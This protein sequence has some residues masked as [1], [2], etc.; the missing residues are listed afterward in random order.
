MNFWSRHFLTHFLDLQD[1]GLPFWTCPKLTSSNSDLAQNGFRSCKWC[2][3]QHISV[4]VF[5]KH[6]WLQNRALYFG[7]KFYF[8]FLDFFVIFCINDHQYRSKLV[9][10]WICFQ[11]MMIRSFFDPSQTISGNTFV[12]ILDLG[13]KDS[14]LMRFKDHF[15]ISIT[16]FWNVNMKYKCPLFQICTARPMLTKCYA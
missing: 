4:S 16:R 12:Q 8:E 5:L 9:L 6:V 1:F 3:F 14:C 7:H 15:K 13:T 11:N 10:G 2:I